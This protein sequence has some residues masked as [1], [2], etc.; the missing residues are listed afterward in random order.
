M[1]GIVRD[2]V[3]V[4]Q[5][6]RKKAGFAVE[7]RIDLNI[8]L[9]GDYKKALVKFEKYFKTETLVL[10]LSQTISNPDYSGLVNIDD[11]SIEVSMKKSE[12]KDG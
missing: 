2:I 4:I 1:E 3:R 10:N 9:D 7:D 11:G 5:S 6:M 8:K 12:E